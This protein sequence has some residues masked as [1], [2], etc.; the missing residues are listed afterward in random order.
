[1]HTLR[2]YCKQEILRDKKKF[3]WLR[4]FNKV[5]NNRKHKFIFLLRL[6]QLLYRKKSRFFQS[7]GKKINESIMRNYGVEIMLGA[8]IGIGLKVFHPVGIVIA[9]QVKIG[10][11]FKVRQNTT[12][13]R[14]GKSQEPIVIGDDVEVGA[15]SCIIGSGIHIGDNVKIGAMSF[16][17]KSIESNLTY[18]TKKSS[19]TWPIQ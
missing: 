14:D 6:S 18:I 13:G 12:I 17:N 1:M 2:D 19:K 5:R 15:N 4:V 3:S 8:D 7:L 16:V 9:P 10:K 11:N